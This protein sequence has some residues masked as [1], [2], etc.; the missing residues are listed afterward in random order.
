MDIF[1]NEELENL[2]N[3][4]DKALASD[5]PN[6]KQALRNLV[7][8]V[9]LTDDDNSN[10]KQKGAVKKLLNK[11]DDLEYRLGEI[12]EMVKTLVN[13]QSYSSIDRE[14]LDRL[15]QEKYNTHWRDEYLNNCPWDLK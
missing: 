13:N 7:M 6:V 3:V 15:K 2:I 8:I 4:I 9:S 12:M 10:K 14:Y 11:V 5:N 1:I